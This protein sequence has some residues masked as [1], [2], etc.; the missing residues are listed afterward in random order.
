MDDP[1]EP[2]VERARA[3]DP[4]AFAEIVRAT[5]AQLYNLAYQIVRNPQEAEDLVQVAYLRAW[6]A[7]PS[8][9]GEARLSTWLYR[10]TTN[11]CLNR[12]RQLGRVTEIDEAVLAET[13][14]TGPSPEAHTMAQLAKTELW[15]K[16]AELPERYRAVLTL[17][18]QAQLS[19]EDVAATLALPLGTV[20]AQ[21]NRARQALAR[22][23]QGDDVDDELS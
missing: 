8:F 9:R 6:R 22:L 5:Q 3:G 2:W 19:Y 7:L 23:I 21:L 11:A 1:L 17:F 18:Y 15:R 14:D 12:R 20:K 4:E 13:P 10:I 16:V